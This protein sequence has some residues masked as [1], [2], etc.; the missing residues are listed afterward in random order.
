MTNLPCVTALAALS[1]GFLVMGKRGAS[2]TPLGGG[3]SL[4]VCAAAD[5]LA[6]SFLGRGHRAMD[7]AISPPLLQGQDVHQATA[8]S[9]VLLTLDFRG[10]D[11]TDMSSRDIFPLG[12]DWPAAGAVV[13]HSAT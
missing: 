3:P 6:C 9:R 13:T 10:R 2:Q 11:I 12:P 7:V 5:G 4:S 8:I 1:Q